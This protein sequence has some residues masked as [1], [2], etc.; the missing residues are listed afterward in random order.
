MPE[1]RILGAGASTMNMIGR[2]GIG[3]PIDHCEERAVL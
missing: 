3:E 1:A 2:E